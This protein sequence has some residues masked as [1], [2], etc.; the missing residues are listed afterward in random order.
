M[1]SW[2]TQ[3]R[4]PQEH[5]GKLILHVPVTKPSLEVPFPHQHDS[6]RRLGITRQGMSLAEIASQ[7][8]R[9]EAAV[10]GLVYRGLKKLYDLLDEQEQ[11]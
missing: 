2:F 8:Q 5:G 4:Y 6:S 3:P 11:A 7:L 1:L 10:A 9:S